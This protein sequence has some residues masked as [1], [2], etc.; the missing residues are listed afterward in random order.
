MLKIPRLLDAAEIRVLGALMEKEQ[1]TPELYP[2]TVNSLIQASN[3]KTARE[4]VMEMSEGAV[5]GALRQLF[6]EG[7]A[8]RTEGARVTRWR[9]SV[10]VRWSLDPGR[11]AVLTLLLLRGPQTPGELRSRSDRLQVFATVR[12][13]EDALLALASSPDPLIRELE[14]GPGQKESRWTHLLADLSAV[15]SPVSPAVLRY[16]SD[17]GEQIEARVADLNRRVRELERIVA[18]LVRGGQP[19]D[20][21]HAD[22]SFDSILNYGNER[23][24]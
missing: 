8:Q 6:V 19:V 18:G 22:A 5:H 10:D 11:K 15:E 7:L 3:Q 16:S 24:E 20:A 13:L 4:P 12:E 2:L 21:A 14:R 23:T 9:Q 1:T 17:E